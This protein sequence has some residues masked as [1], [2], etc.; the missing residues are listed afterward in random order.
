MTLKFVL[1]TF[2]IAIA[3]AENE[4]W[5][6]ERGRY[7]FLQLVYNEGIFKASKVQ[8]RKKNPHFYFLLL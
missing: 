7:I 2:V 1:L 3:T 5:S 6:N 4:K 8:I